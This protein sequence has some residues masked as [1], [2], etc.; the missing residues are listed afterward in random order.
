EHALKIQKTMASFVSMSKCLTPTSGIKL[1]SISGT[2][3]PTSSNQRVV[4]FCSSPLSVLESSRLPN[5]VA[6]TN[7]KR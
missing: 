2:L 3:I 5:A 1:I 7:N 6:L 4:I